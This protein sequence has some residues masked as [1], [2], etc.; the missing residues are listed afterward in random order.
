[1]AKHN[2]LVGP[3]G[4]YVFLSV[5]GAARLD[6]S[7]P[8]RSTFTFGSFIN[9]E[10][11]MDDAQF[12]IAKTIMKR[13]VM[14]KIPKAK[15]WSVSKE[16]TSWIDSISKEQFQVYLDRL[17]SLTRTLSD[18]GSAPQEAVTDSGTFIFFG[19]YR[20]AEI[21]MRERLDRIGGEA[22]AYYALALWRSIQLEELQEGFKKR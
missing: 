9:R 1:M 21:V 17:R 14:E 4:G 22:T 8:A 16:F 2:V 11:E 20:P 15:R 10:G 6:E 13:V 18:E 3:G 5:N 7:A 12:A 19:S